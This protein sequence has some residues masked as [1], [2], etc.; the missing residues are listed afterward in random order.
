LN[1]FDYE[2]GEQTVKFDVN[3]D[4]VFTVTNPDRDELMGAIGEVLRRVARGEEYHD[5]DAPKN[6]GGG[7]GNGIEDSDPSEQNANLGDFGADTEGDD[8]Y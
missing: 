5:V 4:P 1:E 3:G 2:S 6:H 7:G 8:E